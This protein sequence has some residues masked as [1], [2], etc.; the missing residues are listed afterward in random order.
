MANQLSGWNSR[1]THFYPYNFILQQKFVEI[2]SWKIEKLILK[3]EGPFLMSRWNS[4]RINMWGWKWTEIQRWSLFLPF[5]PFIVI[6]FHINTISYLHFYP[7]CSNYHFILTCFIL[8]F[9]FLSISYWMCDIIGWNWLGCMWQSEL[10][11]DEIWKMKINS[12]K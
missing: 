9:S 5:H 3:L 12:M 8:D 6:Q 2:T 10:L 4:T 11:K 1:Y 7:N